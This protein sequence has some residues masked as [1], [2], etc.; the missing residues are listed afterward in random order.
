MVSRCM[1]GHQGTYAE[2]QRVKNRRLGGR[3]LLVSGALIQPEIEGVLPRFARSLCFI[4]PPR[5]AIKPLTCS[6][7]F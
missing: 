1:R 7:V 6:G 4:Q 2:P 5:D 3:G